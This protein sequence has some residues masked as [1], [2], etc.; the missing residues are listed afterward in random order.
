MV[1]RIL[2]KVPDAGMWTERLKADNFEIRDGFI[3][4]FESQMPEVQTISDES[5]IPVYSIIKYTLI[6]AYKQDVIMSIEPV[7]EENNE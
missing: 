3:S 4:F 2:I 1:Y 6:K 7:E 5:A